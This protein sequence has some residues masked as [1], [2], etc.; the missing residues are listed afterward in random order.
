MRLEDQLRTLLCSPLASDQPK[1]R[2]YPLKP[3]Q[4]RR[5]ALHLLL[6]YPNPLPCLLRLQM[7]LVS[8]LC[9][10]RQIPPGR[11]EVVSWIGRVVGRVIEER[12][13]RLTGMSSFSL[14]K[15]SSK[16]YALGQC[17]V[18]MTDQCVLLDQGARS[19]ASS[20]HSPYEPKTTHATSLSISTDRRR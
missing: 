11:T 16:R 4:T 15:G 10:L 14:C 13:S 7:A 2:I 8:I 19:P 18:L 1:D 12:A 20:A 17:S 9:L 5:P 6:R 3:L